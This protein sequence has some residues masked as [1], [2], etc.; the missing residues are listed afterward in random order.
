MLLGALAMAPD[1]VSAALAP[2]RTTRGA[3]TAAARE[4]TARCSVSIRGTSVCP[5]A[6][7]RARSEEG[8]AKWRAVGEHSVWRRTHL[9]SERVL[10]RCAYR[11][12]RW[13]EA[14]ELT[15]LR[16]LSAV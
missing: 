7:S 1:T 14:R 13:R 9:R 11:A 2:T 3:G 4:Q 5:P 8:A 10:H 12:G 16:L 15:S 6:P